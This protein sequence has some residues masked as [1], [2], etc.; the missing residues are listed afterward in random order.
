MRVNVCFPSANI[1]FC[2]KNKIPHTI[3]ASDPGITS[4]SFS[5]LRNELAKHSPGF[6]S[7]LQVTKV[8]SN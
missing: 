3:I 8:L 6:R 7:S 4:V 5:H 1:F 2:L